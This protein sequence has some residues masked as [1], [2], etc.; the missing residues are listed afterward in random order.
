MN[1]AEL[2][3]VCIFAWTMIG[4]ILWITWMDDCCVTGDEEGVKAAK[5]QMK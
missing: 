5:E 2:N 3:R 1:K 4:L